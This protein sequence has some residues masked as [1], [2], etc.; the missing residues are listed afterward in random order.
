MQ[1]RPCWGTQTNPLGI[2]LISHVYHFLLFQLSGMAAGHVGENAQWGG[3]THAIC[4]TQ[5]IAWEYQ[6]SWAPGVCTNRTIVTFQM[7]HHII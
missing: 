3:Y 5:L 2:Q 6:E 7:I 1:R 4:Q